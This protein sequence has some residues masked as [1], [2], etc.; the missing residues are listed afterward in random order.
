MKVIEK[1]RM[2]RDYF[3][4]TRNVGHTTLMKEGTNNYKRDKLILAPKKEYYSFFECKSSEVISWDN[5]NALIGHKKPL[6]ID[7]GTMWV[8]L[9]ESLKE[10][11]KLEKD[12]EQLNKIKKIVKNET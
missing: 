11:T 10:I 7:N 1:L 4:M 8:L 12:S 6:I 9:N 5:L 3:E 2:L